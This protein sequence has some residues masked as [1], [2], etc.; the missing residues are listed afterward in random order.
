MIK[1]KEEKG[2]R[3]VHLGEKGKRVVYL[4]EK[5]NISRKSTKEIT[6]H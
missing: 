6:K 3:V 2:K 4:G 1:K 5:G